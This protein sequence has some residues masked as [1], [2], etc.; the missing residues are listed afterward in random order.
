MSDHALLN[1]DTARQQPRLGKL[2]PAKSSYSLED[3]RNALQHVMDMQEKL[4]KSREGLVIERERI[5]TFGSRVR[6]KRVEAGDTEATFMSSLRSFINDVHNKVPMELPK[7]LFDAYNKVERIR[8]ELGALEEEFL[9]AERN[10]AGAEWTFMDKENDF[11]QFE[12]LDALEEALPESNLDPC[13]DDE[14]EVKHTM[15]VSPELLSPTA[16]PVPS[17]PHA[18][19]ASTKNLNDLLLEHLLP[20]SSPPETSF[21]PAT[22]DLQVARLLSAPSSPPPPAPPPPPHVVLQPPYPEPCTPQSSDDRDHDIVTAELEILRRTFASL[23]QSRA[24]QIHRM[25]DDYVLADEIPGISTRDMMDEIEERP[26][27]DMLQ[28]ISCHEVEAQRLEHKAMF[29]EMQIGLAIPRRCSDPIHSANAAPTPSIF[30]DKA[31][32]ETALPMLSNDPEIKNRLR[33][34]LF[35][36]LKEDPLQRTMYRNILVHHGLESPI[37][38]TWEERASH[39][40]DIDNAS[41]YETQFDDDD[42]DGDGDGNILTRATSHESGVD[43]SSMPFTEF[44]GYQPHLLGTPHHLAVKNHGGSNITQPRSML[45]PSPTR[46]SSPLHPSSALASHANLTG[47]HVFSASTSNRN[48]EYSVNLVGKQHPKSDA[49]SSQHLEQDGVTQGLPDKT[50]PEDECKAEDAFD[51]SIGHKRDTTR[52]ILC[53]R[54]QQLEDRLLDQQAQPKSSSGIDI[55]TI[56]TTDADEGLAKPNN[57]ELSDGQPQTAT[58]QL[59]EKRNQT[60]GNLSCKSP[61]SQLAMINIK[62]TSRPKSEYGEEKLA[63][64]RR[65]R[66]SDILS[67]FRHHSRTHSASHV[68][69]SRDTNYDIGRKWRD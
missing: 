49:E 14:Q 33:A 3:V 13:G 17:P 58:A 31:L 62:Q 64:G 48:E 7:S 52:D 28:Q 69:G 51:R 23:R 66:L 68:F 30:M 44:E 11:Y 46:L 25:D 41:E 47:A 1:N 22:I 59:Q 20:P 9:Q 36:R 42:G 19:L 26:Y 40:W 53:Q 32:T 56:V 5:R 12:L 43:E 24:D 57:I 63:Q 29:R 37:D 65:E 55:P 27:F 54:H 35:A 10:L 8:N 45:L 61:W 50:K 34:W 15:T 2:H 38:E 67:N 39:Y 4:A 21:H 60:L 6:K 18:E 16:P